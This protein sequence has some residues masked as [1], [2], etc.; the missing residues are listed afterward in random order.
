MNQIFALS[1]KVFKAAIIKMCQQAITY[2]LETKER[3]ENLS[4]EIEIIKK[5]N[6]EIIELKSVVIKI[7]SI[8]GLKSR[9]EITED[10]ISELKYRL[11][12]GTQSEI[13][14]NSGEQRDRRENEQSIRE[15]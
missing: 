14:L 3:I 4:K 5:N 12:E 2:T 15:L 11:L 8:D 7:N 10:R 1:D 9:L 13:Y 6:M